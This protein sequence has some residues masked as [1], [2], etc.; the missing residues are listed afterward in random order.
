[1]KAFVT[2]FLLNKAKWEDD[3]DSLL[4]AS[5]LPGVEDNSIVDKKREA[6]ENA[7]KVIE[8]EIDR[9]LDNVD[10]L[11]NEQ[12]TCNIKLAKSNLMG[13]KPKKRKSPRRKLKTKRSKIGDALEQAKKPKIIQDFFD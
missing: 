7:W 8:A 10:P 9:Q 13:F 12:A 1:M 3:S 5:P 6:L 2:N 11:E 4:Y